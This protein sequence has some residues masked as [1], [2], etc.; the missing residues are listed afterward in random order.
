[1]KH[2]APLILVRGGGDLATGVAIRLHR[3]GFQVVVTEIAQP[4]AVRRLV[5]LAEAIYAG[6]ISIEGVSARRVDDVPGALRVLEKNLIPVLVDP[7]ATSREELNPAALVDGRMHKLPTT[8]DLD[9]VPFVIGIG[10]GFHVGEN[11]HAVV[12]SNR[13]HNLGR[14]FW[15]GSAQDDT[16]IPEPIGN[17]DADRVLRAPADGFFEGRIQLA[18][19]VKKGDVIAR[20]G[21]VPLHAP[22]GGVLRGILHDGLEVE[23]GVKVGDLDPRGILEYCFQI[24]D[25]ALAVGG[26]VLEALLSKAEIRSRLRP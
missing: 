14:V 25:K 6:Q 21:N 15:S 22:F 23:R 9:S 24:S 4:L 17:F 2:R 1:M 13:G 16:G 10:P 11:C 5:A 3:C 12:E 20:V 19:V 7:E 8:F 26:G 18:S